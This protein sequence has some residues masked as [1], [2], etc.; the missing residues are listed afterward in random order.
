MDGLL[1]DKLENKIERLIVLSRSL[2]QENEQLKEELS[3]LQNDKNGIK[4]RIDTILNRLQKV[5]E[6]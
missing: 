2:R 3:R 4:D 6:I 5:D 1:F